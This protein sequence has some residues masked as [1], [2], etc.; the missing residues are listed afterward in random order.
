MTVPSARWVTLLLAACGSGGGFP[1]APGVDAPPSGNFS[2]AWSVIDGTNQPVACDRIGAQSM[3]VLTH[4]RAFSGGSTQIFTCDT[5]MGQSQAL[6]AG[7]YDFG[8][9][10]SGTFG[11]LDTAPDQLDIPIPA[12][13]ITPLAPVAFQ[14]D[15]TGAL[16]LTLAT[17]MANCDVTGANIATMS[18]TMTDNADG[19]CAPLTLSI[20]AGATRGASTYAINC[21]APTDGVCIESDQVISATT[22][23]TSGSYTIRVRAKKT[24]ITTPCWVNSDTIQVPPLGMTLSR[25]LN[26]AHQPAVPGC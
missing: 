25:V 5:G 22:A 11:V 15:A 23:V 6:I 24:A 16:A 10:L 21:T 26:L 17:G 14:V 13:A 1:D 2:L 3:T 9:E 12:G 4:N 7:R 19:S 8:F 18:I 20:A